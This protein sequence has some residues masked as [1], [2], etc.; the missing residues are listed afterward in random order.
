MSIFPAAVQRA[1]VYNQADMHRLASNP[2]DEDSVI[3]ERVSTPPEHDISVIA[4]H[5]IAPGFVIHRLV[6]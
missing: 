2:G 6:N 1:S 5:E 4:R 3:G